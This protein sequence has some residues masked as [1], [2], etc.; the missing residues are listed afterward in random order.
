MAEH[1]FKVLTKL[2]WSF[3]HAGLHTKRIYRTED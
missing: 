1:T 3:N 2:K